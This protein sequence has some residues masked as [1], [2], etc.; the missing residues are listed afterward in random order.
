MARAFGEIITF[1][2]YKGGTGRSMCMANL[3]HLLATDTPYGGK[4]VLAIDYGLHGLRN[5]PGEAGKS[6]AR[7]CQPLPATAPGPRQITG[8]NPLP[9]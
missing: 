6:S 1:Y 7:S 4:Q 3:A 8:S 2:S 5:R 9:P